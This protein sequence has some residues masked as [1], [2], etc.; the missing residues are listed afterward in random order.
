MLVNNKINS[1]KSSIF[2]QKYFDFYFLAHNLYVNVFHNETLKIIQV[3]GVLSQDGIM[4][5]IN[6]NT[7]KLLFDIGSADDRIS[8]V[9]I[10]SSGRH[11]VAVIDSGNM[12]VYSVQALTSEL[13][14][15]IFHFKI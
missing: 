11:I 4:R 3:L 2:S 8:N 15:V 7:C 10:S 6:I 1:A 13:N 12:H 9:A 5:F 14:K